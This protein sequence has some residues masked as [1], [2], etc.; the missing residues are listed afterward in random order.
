MATHVLEQQFMHFSNQSL[1][2]RAILDGACPKLQR[3]KIVIHFAS[4]GTAFSNFSDVR[5]QQLRAHSGIGVFN[6]AGKLGFAAQKESN[7]AL[8]IWESLAKTG[9]PS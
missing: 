6:P 4:I 9:K 5:K 3:A 1:S 2:D 7:Q 8:W